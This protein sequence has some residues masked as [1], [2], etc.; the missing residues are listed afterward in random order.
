MLRKKLE[1]LSPAER[2]KLKGLSRRRRQEYLK[3]KRSP[4]G[5]NIISGRP[6]RCAKR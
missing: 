1:K 2:E 4:G 3:R 6:S 5:K